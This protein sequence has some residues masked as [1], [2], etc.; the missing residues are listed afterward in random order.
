MEISKNL[1]IILGWIGTAIMI[2]LAILTLYFNREKETALE[3][4]KISETELTRPLN[5][6]RLSST[7]MYDDSIPV[8]HLWQTSYVIKNTG[9]TTIFG[10]GYDNKNIRG[11]ALKLHIKNCDHLL[12]LDITD[13]NTDAILKS[14]DSLQ[15]VQWRPNEYVELLLLSDG[16]SAPEISISDRDIQNVIISEVTF[17]PEEKPSAKRWIDH[18]PLSF[19]KALWWVVIIFYI[20][21]AI[22]S[23]ISAV[24]QYRKAENKITRT[25]TLVVW[26]ITFIFM[27]APLLWMF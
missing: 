4:K 3:I 12:A 24:Q 19:S 6:A 5:V 27:L 10:E 18:L 7:Y 2:V 16:S 23:M 26:I 13:N 11:N 15:F 17:S 25:I 20:I 22:F 14:K 9:E 21:I 1:R 8:E